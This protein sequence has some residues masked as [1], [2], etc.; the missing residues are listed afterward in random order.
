MKRFHRASSRVDAWLVLHYL[1]AAG[2]R[3]HVFN[4]HVSSI[5]GEVPPDIAMPEVWIED[6]ADEARARA[7]VASMR[8]GSTDRAPR[9][10]SECGE[11]NPGNF[12]LC[13]NCGR[14]L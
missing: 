14:S 9:S 13:W 12:D 4:T 5:V 7:I 11:E 3:A 6:P 1:Q 2:I 10:C 8:E